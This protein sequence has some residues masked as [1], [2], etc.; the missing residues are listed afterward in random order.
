MPYITVYSEGYIQRG[1]ERESISTD[2]FIYTL[3]TTFTVITTQEFSEYRKE[4]I[5]IFYKRKAI[6]H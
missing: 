5:F 6:N 4:N 1:M 3:E 2:C